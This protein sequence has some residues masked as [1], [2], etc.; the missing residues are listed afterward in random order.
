MQEISS[1]QSVS[2]SDSL[3]SNRIGF[4]DWAKTICIFLMV[5]GHWSSNHHLLLT[6]I[7]SF[8]MP[9]LF[10]IS[11]FLFKPHAWYKTL[12]S[13]A[14]P[15]TFFSVV[16]LFVQLFLGEIT[17]D[18]II[19]PQLI[20]RIFHY[21][22]GL[23]ANLFIGDWFLWALLGLR[24]LFGD[25]KQLRVTRKYYFIIS[26]VCVFYMTF[27]SY[28]VSVDTIFR[29]YLIGRMIPS[30]IFFCFGFYIFDRKWKPESVS[31][32]YIIPLVPLFFLLPLFNGCCGIVA[33]EYGVSYL[34][35]AANAILSSVLLFVLCTKIP[36]TKFTE[37]ISSGTFVVLGTHIPILNILN[38]LLPNMISF[39][40][41]F[42]TIVICYYI[43]VLCEKYCPI[44]LGKWKYISFT[45]K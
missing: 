3:G 34:I 17:F 2:C 21:R 23:G 10:I 40:Y 36:T 7:C 5:V 27:E 29:G 26:L 37:T 14:I 15:V 32:F 19:F 8:H 6:Y 18:E 30:L 28:L 24:F 12:L 11:G 31:K 44:L 25:V 33:N 35:F 1:M 22:Y 45:R 13:Y 9:A 16:N 20:F 43:I 42:I 4:V 41:P 39:M 38:H